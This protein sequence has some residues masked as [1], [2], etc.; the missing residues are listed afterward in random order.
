MRIIK[1]ISPLYRS[2]ESLTAADEKELETDLPN[3]ADIMTPRKFTTVW[4]KY[5]YTLNQ[6]ADIETKNAWTIKANNV[7]S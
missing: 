1:C 2:N 4:E 3:P 7:P 5:Q 6:I